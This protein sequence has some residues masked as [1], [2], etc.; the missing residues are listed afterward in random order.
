MQK[1]E[2]KEK[3]IEWKKE[4]W[5]DKMN[6]NSFRCVSLVISIKWYRCVHFNLYTGIHFFFVVTI[7]FLSRRQIHRLPMRNNCWFWIYKSVDSFSVNMRR[8]SYVASF[9]Q[10]AFFMNNDR[11]KI[12]CIYYLLSS[13]VFVLSVKNSFTLS[14]GRCCSYKCNRSFEDRLSFLESSSVFCLQFVDFPDFLFFCFVVCV[15]VLFYCSSFF[16]SVSHTYTHTLALPLARSMLHIDFWCSEMW[17]AHT[18]D[19]IIFLAYHL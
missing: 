1:M 13:S 8:I 14:I 4:G 11:K 12:Q 5:D 17:C 6:W 2:T 3:N 7:F 9:E 16:Q 15:C 10:C 19:I 18:G